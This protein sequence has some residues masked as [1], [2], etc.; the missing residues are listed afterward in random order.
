MADIR[1]FLFSSHLRAEASSHIILY[2]GG[3]Q[4]RSG[5]GLSFWFSTWRTSIVEIPLDDRDTEFLFQVR[6]QDFQPVTVQGTITWRTA[7]AAVLAQRTDFTINLTTGRLRSDPLDRIASLLIGLAQ[8][9][10]ARYIETR[11]VQALLTEGSG[12]L[13]QT[14]ETALGASER[15]RG[16]GLSV[17][18]VRLAGVSPSSD[19]ARAL[20]TPTF[21]KLQERADE[22]TFARR[23]LAVESERAIAQNE[24][25][26]K[27]E[28]ARR[29][30]ALIEQ[31]TENEQRRATATAEAGRIAA[32]AEAARTRVLGAASTETERARLEAAQ[33]VPPS[34]HYALAARALAGKL[35]K[36]D[37]LTV[38]PDLA[39]AIA[40]IL[41]GNPPQP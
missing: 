37:N 6:S 31:E 18:T 19:L 9:Q 10:A 14:I 27:V 20:E 30:G 17:V 12:P 2:R 33:S 16:M 26:T 13:R 36:I 28:L 35:G 15:L 23:A 40:S 29:Q 21:E 1:P 22:A 38:T 25:S 8:D 7:D 4:A 11:T 3:Q 24:L 41:R 39:A 34:V 5:R 32:D